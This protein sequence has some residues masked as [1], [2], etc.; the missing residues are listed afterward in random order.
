M[1]LRELTFHGTPLVLVAEHHHVI[2]PWTRFARHTGKKYNLITLDH[3]TDVLPAFSRSELKGGF[4]FSTEDSVLSA[5]S[6]LRHD[7]HIDWALRSGVLQSAK[8]LSHENFTECAHPAIT[9]SCDSV[10][11]D[12]QEILK[13]SERAVYAAEQVLETEYLKRQI[14]S[15]PESL[16]LDIDLDNFLTAKALHPH[17]SSYFLELAKRAELITVSL[18]R[19]WVR[20]LRFR[21]ETIT[22]ETLF[23]E[24]LKL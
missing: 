6:L 24:L 9:V 8:I 11:P 3:H 10:W 12:T 15:I 4:D 14:P 17:D 19:D 5:L 13:G 7:E 1:I 23:E 2:I 20:C 16:I 21:N 18:E 22:A